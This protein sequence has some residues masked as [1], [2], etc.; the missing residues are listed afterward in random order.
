[1]R[2]SKC[3]M[4]CFHLVAVGLL[5]LAVHDETAAQRTDVDSA[6]R[7]R[8]LLIGINNYR[9]VP[10]LQ[11]SLNDVETIKQVLLTRWGFEEANIQSLTNEKATRDGI[12]T[13][14]KKFVVDTKPPDTIYIHYS[15]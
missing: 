1:M 12:L 3:H 10:K 14:L 9:A 4:K 15:G 13:A 6:G 2:S 7:K 5:C 11:G 8:A